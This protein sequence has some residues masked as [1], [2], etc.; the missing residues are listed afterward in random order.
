MDDERRRAWEKELEDDRAQAQFEEAS[1]ELDHAPP[2]QTMG[3]P[4]PS[5]PPIK[6]C[7]CASYLA[8]AT[9]DQLIALVES[10]WRAAEYWRSRAL[11]G[12]RDARAWRRTFYQLTACTWIVIAVVAALRWWG[13]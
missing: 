9:R 10:W 2:S 4:D 7:D 8:K 5:L 3:P 6:S 1:R 11:H 13:R 12:E